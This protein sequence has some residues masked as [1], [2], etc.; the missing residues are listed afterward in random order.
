MTIQERAERIKLLIMDV[1]G[2]LTDGRIV[3]NEKG[4]GSKFFNVK[5]GLGLI[6]LSHT[7]IKSA[8]ITA[9]RSKMV[10]KRAKYTNVDLVYQDVHDKAK[11]YEDIKKKLKLSD[12][13]CAFIGDDLIDLSVLKR[14]GLAISVSDAVEEVKSVCHYVTSLSGGRGAVREAIELILKSQGK[15]DSILAEYSA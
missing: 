2:V 3:Y 13:E 10:T 8:I 1:D 9:R 15:W 11:V 4:V 5:D 14:V 12:E 6:I 7:G